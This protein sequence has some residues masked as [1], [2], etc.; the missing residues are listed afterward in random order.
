MITLNEGTK[1]QITGD[2]SLKDGIY[3]LKLWEINR[4]VRVIQTT[5]LDGYVNQLADRL[6]EDHK[7][8]NIK[9]YIILYNM[10]LFY[11]ILYYII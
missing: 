2:L 3:D 6:E 8:Y 10:I 11:I 1:T 7:E 9:H 5:E 4:Q